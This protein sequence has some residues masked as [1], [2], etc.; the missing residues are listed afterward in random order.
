MQLLLDLKN[1]PFI[2]WLIYFRHKRIVLKRNTGK[3]LMLGTG[4][5]IGTVK[6]GTNILL[7]DNIT[8]SNCS[9]GDYSYV[10][11]NSSIANADIGKYSCIGS[12]VS[13]GLGIHPINFV[14][15]HPT[16]YTNKKSH[17]FADKDHFQEYERTHIGNDVWI[18]NNS[19]IM[20][21]LTIGDGAV[22]AAGAVV[23]KDVEPYAV[24]GGI[25]A[26]VLKFRFEQS[27]IE[28]IR[29]T[30]WWNWPIE[31]IKTNK[32]KFLNVEE[33]LMTEELK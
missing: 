4:N 27:K 9:I 14:S 28:H 1:I 8:M 32:D 21:G 33:F 26:K 5:S 18:G 22:I 16:F 19:I 6:F 12:Q 10:N 17:Y 3:N 31:K 30:N 23:T 29:A 15:T 13:I 7:T 2:K 25:P 20:G 24:V 11:R